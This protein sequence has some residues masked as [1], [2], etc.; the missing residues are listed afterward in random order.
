MIVQANVR[1]RDLGSFVAEAQAKVADQVQAPPSGWIDWGGQFENLQRASARLGLIVPIVFL[2]IGGLLVLA[3]RSWKDAAIVFAGVPL[4][5]VGG[6]LALALRG[7]P[8]S[9]SAA[10]GFIAVSGVATLNGLVLMQAIRERTAAGAAPADAAFDGAV[11][12]LRA[13]MTTALVA[14]LGFVPMAFASGAGA[15]VQKPL[16][17]VVI[18]GLITATLLTL[19]VLPMLVSLVGGRAREGRRDG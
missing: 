5:L 10:V 3:L 13:I 15:E 6:V 18:G 4:A 2:T 11:G 7:M 19:F 17:T 9:I 1:G 8:L 14:V 16:A 12:R